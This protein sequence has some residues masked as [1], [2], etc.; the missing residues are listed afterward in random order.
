MNVLM[1]ADAVG[2]VWTYAVTLSKTLAA[3]G[4]NIT[5]AVMG[6]PPTA[7]QREAVL[8]VPGIA[9]EERPYRLEW[10]DTP[11][12]DVERA[13][14]WLL[15]LANRFAPDVVHLNGYAHGAL[16]WPAPVL[17]TGHSCV[18]SWWQ[19]VKRTPTPDSLETYRA[20]V[21]NGLRATDHVV[22]PSRFMLDELERLY[23]P[24]P[25]SRVVPNGHL[26]GLTDRPRG[27]EPCILAAGRLWDEAKNLAALDRA[28]GLGVPWPVFVAGDTHDPDGRAFEARH[29]RLL[30]RLPQDE[31][32]RR[33]G[34]ASIYAL[35]ARY[36]PFGLSVLEAAAA[37][38][39]LVLG[40]IPSLRENW[41]DAALFVDPDDTAGL[42]KAMKTLAADP[43]LRAVL[44]LQARRRAALF[45][46]ER[47]AKAYLGVY[48]D[49]VAQRQ[50][51]SSLRPALNSPTA[52]EVP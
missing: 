42:A 34:N 43:G 24:L 13:G 12:S 9:L 4:V 38:C 21:R 33:M 41:S 50:Q 23:G 31:L 25:P 2:G 37:G 15:S 18:L 17:I 19:A 20:R 40:D 28:A 32:A 35:P 44:A 26:G 16:P 14:E 46:A 8:G 48:R 51:T 49:L 39:A 30:G 52:T 10:M 22:A 36:E 3:R 6:P 47:Q 5:L 1:T 45:T 29:A 11:W 7:D 27:K